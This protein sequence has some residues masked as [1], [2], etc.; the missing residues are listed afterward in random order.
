MSDN[1][2]VIRSSNIRYL[3]IDVNAHIKEGWIPIGGVAAMYKSRH[4]EEDGLFYQ[5]MI[6]SSED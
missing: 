1:Y 4:G 3:E 6:K 2:K 5:A